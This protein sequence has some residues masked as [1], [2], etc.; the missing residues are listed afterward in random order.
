MDDPSRAEFRAM[1]LLT[2]PFPPLPV[3][4]ARV[5]R[6]DGRLQ[7]DAETTSHALIARGLDEAM[8]RDRPGE[9]RERRARQVDV[10]RRFLH[11][12]AV[13]GFACTDERLHQIYCTASLEHISTYFPPGHPL[14][15]RFQPLSSVCKRD[16][17]HVKMA[18]YMASQSVYYED[19]VP[20]R[21][22]QYLLQDFATMLK[23]CRD[24]LGH[25]MTEEERA[26][27]E[28]G[29]DELKKNEEA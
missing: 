8:A 3:L 22:D 11:A 17:A 18:E 25:I 28:N 19:S 6:D 29:L 7:G 16:P 15:I 12:M 5:E 4:V 1:V 24:R 26:R 20:V 27:V 9:N 21:R 2:L 10:F 23:A 13:E 14:D